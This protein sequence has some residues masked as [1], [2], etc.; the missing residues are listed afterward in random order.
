MNVKTLSILAGLIAA[1]SAAMADLPDEYTQ[2]ANLPTAA[3]ASTL[4]RGDVRAAAI[5]AVRSGT[6]AR[7]EYE[8]NLVP[9]PVVPSALQRVQVLAEAVEA[10]KLGLI[11]EGEGSARVATPGQLEQIRL[12][13]VAA[14]NRRVAAK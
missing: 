3:A 11:P 6:V 2:N 13:G 8:R 7:N 1:S 14:V 4:S 12:A 10:R 5:E 9:A